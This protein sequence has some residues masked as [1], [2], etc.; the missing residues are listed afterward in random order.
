MMET[1]KYEPIVYR[2]YDELSNKHVGK[3]N[4][5]SG[6]DLSAIFEI[7]ER[8]L[9]IYIREIRAS[10]QLTKIV[11][12]CKKGYYI[13][14]EEEGTA[15]VKRLFRHSLSTLKIAKA[16]VKKAELERQCKIHLGDY[17]KEYVEVFGQ[18]D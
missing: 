18:S 12:T 5:I 6:S 14:T 3:K 17:Y 9:R 8:K 16:T 7:S 1:K 4:A 10:Q 15:D 2:I 13:P 11:L